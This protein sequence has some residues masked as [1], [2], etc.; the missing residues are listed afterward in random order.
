MVFFV[1]RAHIKLRRPLGLPA[2]GF[3]KVLIVIVHMIHMSFF[4]NDIIYNSNFNKNGEAAK[5]Q[6]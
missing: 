1:Q 4:K 2:E 3:F 5:L 6:Y